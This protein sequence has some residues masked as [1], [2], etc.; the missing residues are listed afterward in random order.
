MKL[1]YDKLVSDFAF[2]CNMRHYITVK[3]VPVHMMYNV[4]VPYINQNGEVA[5]VGRCRL[6]PR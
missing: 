3:A 5:T 6:T 1:K 2:N 4:K